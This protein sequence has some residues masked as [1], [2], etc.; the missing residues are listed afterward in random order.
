MHA[1][2]KDYGRISG[3]PRN[4]EPDLPA[5]YA[6]LHWALP[7]THA[8][9]FG[10]L[11]ILKSQDNPKLEIIYFQKGTNHSLRLSSLV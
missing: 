7:F 6:L 1:N 9:L 5:G 4:K 11:A 10:P 3:C 2:A 8:L